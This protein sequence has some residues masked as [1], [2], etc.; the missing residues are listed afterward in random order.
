MIG[1]HPRGS[2]GELYDALTIFRSVKGR[3]HGLPIRCGRHDSKKATGCETFRHRAIK[4]GLI[5]RGSVLSSFFFSEAKKL[6]SDFR[7]IF[8]TA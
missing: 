2:F 8:Y 4:R 1:C 6:L 3:G 7:F 5:E